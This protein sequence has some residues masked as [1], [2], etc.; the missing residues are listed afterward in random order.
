MNI[1]RFR[2]KRLSEA[3]KKV[4]YAFG[5]DAVI[6]STRSLR[7]GVEVLA[8]VDF[9]VEAIEKASTGDDAIKLEIGHLRKEL[10]ELKHLFSTVVKDA[11]IK[12]LAC[13]GSGALELYQDMLK[14]GI[15]ERLSKRLIKVAASSMNGGLSLSESC[16]RILQERVALANP[17]S[18]KE[19][20]RMLAL[21][22]PTGVGKTTTVAKLAGRLTRQFRAKVGMVSVD[23]SGNASNGLLKSCAREFGA[24]LGEPRSKNEFNKI[25]WG[26]RDKDVVLVDTP[27]RSPSDTEGIGQLKN[28]LYDGL[29]IKTGLVLSMTSGSD[30]LTEA[31]RG[32]ERLP[33]DCHIF[34][35][36]DEVNS[37]G[38]II[39]TYTRTKKPIAYLCNGQRIPQDIGVASHE[40]LGNLVFGRR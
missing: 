16:Y 33:I 1:N 19:K 28:V 26:F 20:P 22:G 36:L 40:M 7:G 3:L 8:A 18:H 24:S 39:N 29:P 14:R 21:V 15:D 27:G 34:T 38:S 6:L 11:E 31:C 10:G 30:N 35:K 25:M 37:F 4:K 17:L 9:D 5:E 2:G 12:E 32:F 13:L 23:T